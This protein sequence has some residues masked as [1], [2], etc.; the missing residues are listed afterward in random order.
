MADNN[1][2]SFADSQTESQINTD[3]GIQVE[4]L[5]IFDH[6]VEESVIST[7][8][9]ISTP[10]T[11]KTNEKK[12]SMSDLFKLLSKRFDSN[13]EKFNEQKNEIQEFKSSV[14]EKLD[15][16]ND[17]FDEL[18]NDIQEMNKRLENTNEIIKNSLNKLEQSIERMGV[19]VMN[20]NKSKTNEN[21]DDM[22]KNVVLDKELTNDDDDVENN[23]NNIENGNVF[24]KIVS[25]SDTVKINSE[26]T[27]EVVECND[28][29]LMC[30]Y[31]SERKW[32]DSIVVEWGQ[33][34]NFPYIYDEPG[35]SQ[36]LFLKGKSPV[37][38]EDFC[39]PVLYEFIP[40]VWID[41]K[42]MRWGYD[43]R[44]LDRELC[45]ERETELYELKRDYDGWK[46][47]LEVYL[48]KSNLMYDEKINDPISNIFTNGDLTEIR[49]VDLVHDYCDKTNEFAFY[50]YDT[51][52]S[53]MCVTDIEN[54]Y[55]KQRL[56]FDDGG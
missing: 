52:D 34:V 20:T 16:Q 56:I 14:H 25:E 4:S 22:C 55:L 2:V 18:K 46:E 31:E 24:E 54:C 21:Y 32:K 8:G 7:P 5:S 9:A 33:R 44:D 38:I 48:N 41:I 11:I 49:N 35:C 29:M 51:Q 37:L 3:S 1:E 13:D 23:K 36:V 30:V 19:D 28:G 26:S 17:K 40:S 45:V 53:N 47:M 10:V 50:G 6:N 15:I 43:E 27:D 39:F 42:S 12:M